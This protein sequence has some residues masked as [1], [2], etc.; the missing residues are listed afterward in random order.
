PSHYLLYKVLQEA[1]LTPADVVQVKV[2]DPS[3]AG[4]AFVGG[5]VDAAVTWEPFISSARKTGKGK[6]L[7]TTRDYPGYVVDVLV[8]SPRLLQNQPLLQNFLRGW[9]K[10]VDYMI[11]HPKECRKPIADG[12]HMD[13]QDVEIMMAGLRLA[14]QAMNQK[15]LCKD[16]LRPA[17]LESTLADAGKFWKD[18]GI[19]KA[20]PDTSSM[21]TSVAIDSANSATFSPSA[22]TERKKIDLLQVCAAL[23]VFVGCLTVFWL[24]LVKSGAA[25]TL[26]FSVGV[27]KQ[28]STLISAVYWLSPLAMIALWWIGCAT[29]VL[30]SKFIPAPQAVLTS[31]F[32]LTLNGTLLKEGLISFS[33]IVIGFSAASM[34]GVAV[35]LAAGSF[36]AA[37]QLITPINS[38]LRYIP[39]TAFVALLIVYCGVDELFKYAVVFVGVV[40]FV[41]QMVIDV[42]EDTE[43]GYLEMAMTS[44]LS[45]WGIF[46]QVILPAAGP[47]VFDVLRINLSATWTF[48]VV[49]ELIGSE[50]GLGHFVA[51]SQRFLRL[52]DLFAGIIVFGIIGLSTD[53]L[54]QRVGER[55][56]AWQQTTKH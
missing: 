10:S 42:V 20:L 40:F 48:L 6:V 1:K 17:R 53:L 44:G 30:P 35:G 11:T 24:A 33:R 23:V 49:A 56:F 21:M 36:L 31:L 55:L 28:R 46:L 13:I 4:Q 18:Q 19:I 50:Q 41:V 51:I 15:Y 16:A 22:V 37:K 2:E 3:S 34:V 8:V 5:S 7:V 32:T 26:T 52:D 9:Q 47:R 45:N 43:T 14:D 25:T 27:P 54:L 38:F 29:D 12:F 39:P